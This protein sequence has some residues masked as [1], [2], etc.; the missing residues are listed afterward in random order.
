MTMTIVEISRYDGNL[1]VQLEE[2]IV[3]LLLICI[4][5]QIPSSMYSECIS[6]AYYRDRPGL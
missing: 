5:I 2:K 4:I 6:T 1:S 3:V